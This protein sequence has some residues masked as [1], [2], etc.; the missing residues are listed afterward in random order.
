MSVIDNSNLGTL[1]NRILGL[2]S[3]RKI[4]NKSLAKDITINDEDI[5]STAVSGE[6]TVEGALGNIANQLESQS[7]QIAALGPIANLTSTSNTAA[8]AASQGKAL[9]DL[10]VSRNKL[11]VQYVSNPSIPEADLGIS[12]W[13]VGMSY[14]IMISTYLRAAASADWMQIGKIVNYNGVINLTSQVTY[15]SAGLYLRIL[16][17]GEIY[18]ANAYGTYTGWARDS[19]SN[20]VWR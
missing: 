12:C 6:T 4:N 11:T 18:I 19:F 16:D 20:G 14:Y 5:P 1:W 10:V 8:L 17:T 7:D 15:G 9:S 3:A 13:Q 2:F